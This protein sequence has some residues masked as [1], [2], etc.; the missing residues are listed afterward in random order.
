MSFMSRAICFSA[1]LV[2]LAAFGCSGGDDSPDRGDNGGGSGGGGANLTAFDDFCTGTLTVDKDLMVPWS[3]GGWQSS[4]LVAHAGTKF[5]LEQDFGKF[6]GYVF[7]PDG[8]ATQIDAEWN[9]GLV[10]GT[11]FISDC[12]LTNVTTHFVL[13]QDSNFYASEDLAGEPCTIPAGTQFSSYSFSSMGDVATFSGDKLES[14]CGLEESFTTDILYG[15]LVAQ[16]SSE[17]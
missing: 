16:P 10:Q 11:D 3:T 6:Q 1:L 9:T 7:Q 4:N 5:F 17:F 14:L 15:K 8:S 2:P 13:L 12:D